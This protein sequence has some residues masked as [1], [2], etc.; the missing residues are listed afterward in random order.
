MACVPDEPKFLTTAQAARE[1]GVGKTTLN[2]WA[3]QG[4]VTPAWTT[5]GGQYR[6]KLDD[7]RRQLKV[8]RD[9]EG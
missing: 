1:I 6:W 5:P 4:I 8:P 3:R 9:E 2:S 7:L